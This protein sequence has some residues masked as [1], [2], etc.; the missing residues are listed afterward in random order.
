M[1]RGVTIYF[2]NNKVSRIAGARNTREMQDATAFGEAFLEAVKT[3]GAAAA[4]APVEA[5][6]QAVEPAPRKPRLCAGC[7]QTGHNVR[8]CPVANPVV[9][10]AHEERR[11][12]EKRT[13]RG[14]KRP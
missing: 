8:T 5:P 1:G 3:S 2:K 7:N 11:A 13:S 14:G 9:Q 6:S 12:A 4:P 10:R